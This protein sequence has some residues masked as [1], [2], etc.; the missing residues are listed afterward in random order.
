VDSKKEFT[1]DKFPVM[2]SFT[3]G[4]NANRAI[5]KPEGTMQRTLNKRAMNDYDFFKECIKNALRSSLD[6]MAADDVAIAFAAPLWGVT[7]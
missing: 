3:A 5:G 1:N 2:F 4:P 6:G 7:N